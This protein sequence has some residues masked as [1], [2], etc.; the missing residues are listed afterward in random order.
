MF[1]FNPTIDL[2]QAVTGIL[3]IIAG[4]GVIYTMRGDIRLIKMSVQ[5]VKDD[6]SGMQTEIRKIADVMVTL[7]R[8]DERLNSMDKRLDRL[9]DVK[10][11][12]SQQ[13]PIA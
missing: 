12:V 9:M 13:I 3:F 1:T 8:Q 6:M 5:E 4:L 2:G 10:L 11:A 7:G